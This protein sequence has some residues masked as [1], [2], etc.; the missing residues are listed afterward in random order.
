MKPTTAQ[1]RALSR[2]DPLLG[3]ALRR[4]GPFPSF[5]E[6]SQ[7]QMST[8]KYLVRAIAFQQLAYRAAATI[9]SRVLALT[10]DGRLTPEAISKVSDEELRG[11]GLS[12]AKLAAV[13][14][15]SSRCLDGRLKLRGLSRLENS[16]I[17]DQLSAVRG[18]GPWTA[19]MFLIFKLGR[20]DVLPTTDLGVQEGLKRL[21]KLAKRPKP[22]QLEKRGECWSPLASVAAWVLWRVVDDGADNDW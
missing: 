4:L 3:A 6:S 18:I 11:A 13:R 16:T 19:Q 15:L 7:R 5:P 14:D 22:K 17:I 2:R 1:I 8:F 21:D 12:R 10:S 9:F 20:L